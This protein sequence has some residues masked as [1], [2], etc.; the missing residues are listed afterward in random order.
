MK[1][2]RIV[3]Y[4]MILQNPVKKK[5]KKNAD[6]QNHVGNKTINFN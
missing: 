4:T 5:K 3:S 2:S 6:G 1:E